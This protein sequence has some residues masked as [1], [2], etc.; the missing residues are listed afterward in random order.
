[1]KVAHRGYVEHLERGGVNTVGKQ[2]FTSLHSPARERAFTE[3]NILAGQS[4][5]GLFPF[6]L[7]RVL[8]DLPKPVIEAYSSNA[9]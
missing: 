2:H 5:A 3:R 9:E 8:R 4:K 7:D 6:N 1:L